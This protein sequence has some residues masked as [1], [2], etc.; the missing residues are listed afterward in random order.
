MIP[1]AC[2]VLMAFCPLLPFRLVQ[3]WRTT[4][5]PS[6]IADLVLKQKTVRFRFG[7]YRGGA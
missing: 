7:R 4:E 3:C 5:D 6:M 2:V 1:L